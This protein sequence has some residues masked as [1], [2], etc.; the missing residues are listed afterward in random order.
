MDETNSS[1]PT[2]SYPDSNPNSQNPNP[3]TDTN[4]DPNTDPNPNS[5]LETLHQTFNLDLYGKPLSYS[6]AKSGPDRLLWTVAEAEE[7]L[8]LILSGTL[9]PIA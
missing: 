7:I 4:S 9:L 2:H 8:R 1:T 3:N 5:Y 6:T